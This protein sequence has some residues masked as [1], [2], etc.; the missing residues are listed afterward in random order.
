MNFPDGPGE[1]FKGADV[2][3][4]GGRKVKDSVDVLMNLYR[5]MLRIRLCEESFVGPI[6]NKDIRCPVHLCTGQ[7]AVAVGVCSALENDDYIFGN[8]RSH[9]H[10]LAKGG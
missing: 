9:G 4:F 1:R 10:Y 5:I 2:M 6:L 8:H 3:L 7:E